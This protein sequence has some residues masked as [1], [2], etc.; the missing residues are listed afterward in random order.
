METSVVFEQKIS[1]NPRDF[2]QL[3]T[4]NLDDILLEKFETENSGRCS[5]HGW[6]KPGTMK[7]LS[8]SMM[9]IEGGRFTGDMIC[10]VQ[11]EGRVIY[12]VDGARLQGIVMKKNKMGMFV[13]YDEA[14]QVM[15]PRDLHVG[16]DDLATEF[17]NVQIGE[18]VEVEVKKSRFQVR[19]PTILSVGIFKQRLKMGAALPAKSAVQPKAL[20]DE[21]VAEEEVAEEAGGAAASS[22]EE[23]GAEEEDEGEELEI[24]LEDALT[25]EQLPV[26]TQA[27]AQEEE[28]EATNKITL[29]E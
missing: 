8:R 24:N 20:V 15:V 5:V 19:D 18:L 3:G 10:W 17:D 14:I 4:T 7:M 26:G 16:T 21:E 2:N 28:D 29:R 9:Q 22:E 12:P 1:I 13:M 6:V 23:E 27:Q 11:V 25:G